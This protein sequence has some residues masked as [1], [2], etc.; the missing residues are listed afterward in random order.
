MGST[1][2]LAFST[3][4]N[5]LRT[6]PILKL[7]DL[8]ELFILQTDANQNGLGAILLQLEDTRNLIAYASG[9]LNKAELN[10]ATVEKPRL[11]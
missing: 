5:A 4:R 11:G 6:A 2:N 10:Y 7:P 9:K 1:K 3:S 8:T